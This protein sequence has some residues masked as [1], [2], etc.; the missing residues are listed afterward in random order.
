MRQ[1]LG[2][3]LPMICSRRSHNWMRPRYSV[4]WDRLVEAEIVYQRG[5][6]PQ[7]TYTFKH[8]LIQDAAYES[9]LKST[10]QHYHQRIAQVLEA[11]FPETVET[12]P[13]LLAHHCTEAGLSEQA[14]GYWQRAGQQRPRALGPSGSGGAPDERAG[15]ARY[16]PRDPGAGP[17]GARLANHPGTGTAGHQGLRCPGGGADLCPGAGVVRAGRRDAAALSDPVGLRSVLSRPGGVTRRRGSSG[18]SSDR[19]AQR[20]A[21]PTHRLEA[22]GALGQTLFYLGEYAA[23]QT[24]F[25]Q[26]GALTDPAAQRSQALRSDAAP[27]V[28]C[29]AVAT[30]ALWCLGYPAQAVRRSQEALALAQELA[31]PYSLVVALVLGHLPASPPPRG[32]GGPDAGRGPPDA[33]D[34]AGVLLHVGHGTFWRGWALAMQGQGEAGLAQMHQGLTA[35]VATGQELARPLCLVLLA[36]AQGTSATLKKGCACWPRP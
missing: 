15:A 4:S 28:R 24:H 14:V 23:A 31:H 36:E 27:G 8:A 35:V 30:N 11:Q 2:A 10:R 9:L 19:L 26:G 34:C 18:N 16:A 7:A 5:V 3:S 29:L 32:A 12:Q 13:E 21:D 20:A 6:P 22:H 1:S 33:G 25:E 17:A